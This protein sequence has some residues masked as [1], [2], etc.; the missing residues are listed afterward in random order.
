MSI[1]VPYQGGGQPQDIA[2][3]ILPREGMAL[4][5]DMSIPFL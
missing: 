2:A 4:Y 5:P 3:G 1:S